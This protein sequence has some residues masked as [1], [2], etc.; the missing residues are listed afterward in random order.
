MGPFAGGRYRVK[1][2]VDRL[3][4]ERTGEMIEISSDCLILEDV[5][6]GGDRSTCRWFCRR[7]IYPYWRE[8]WVARV[9]DSASGSV[10][11]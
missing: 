5:V 9:D 10:E 11:P 1:N 4:D 7:G 3:V 2:R 6:C 8:A